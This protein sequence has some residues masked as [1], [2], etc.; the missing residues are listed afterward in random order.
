[1]TPHD[2]D[3]LLKTYASEAPAPQCRITPELVIL[4]AHLAAEEARRA[5]AGNLERWAFAGAG[6]GMLFG[7]ALAPVALQLSMSTMVLLAF[8]GVSVGAF[9]WSLER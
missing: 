7:V 2:L 1:M 4:K 3:Q 8:A 5:R 9:A 6:A